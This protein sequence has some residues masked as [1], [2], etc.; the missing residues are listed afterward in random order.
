MSEITLPHD[1]TNPFEQIKQV[2]ADGSEYW[3]ARDL[4]PVLG[5]QQWRRFEDAISRAITACENMGHE[6][7]KHFLPTVAKSIGGRPG[8]DYKLSRYACYLTAMNG[9]PRKSEIASAQNYFAIKT[10]EAELGPEI[11]FQLL[12][13]F[14][15]QNQVIEQQGRAIAEL[16]SQVQNL[17]PISSDFKPP[18]WDASVW[19]SLPPQ[20]KRHFRFIY[21]KHGFRPG[22]EPEPT[23]SMSIEQHG[24]NHNN[25]EV[26]E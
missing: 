18:G 25:L 13:R 11:L 14:D 3:L 4:M 20:D 9:D 19:D 24:T 8:E 6:S 1:N 22:A 7:E 26:S 16:Q 5:Y 12:Q 15:Q 21:K 2:D 23:S 17:L 10:R